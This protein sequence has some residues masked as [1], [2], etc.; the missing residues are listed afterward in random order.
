MDMVYTKHAKRRLEE[1]GLT[2]YHNTICNII[3]KARYM[4][5]EYPVCLKVGNLA[6]VAAEEE[7]PKVITVWET[8]K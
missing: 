3:S 7:S 2:D 5:N 1:R 4:L 8:E 6:V